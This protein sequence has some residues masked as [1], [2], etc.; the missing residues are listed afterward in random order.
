MGSRSPSEAALPTGFRFVGRDRELELLVA[1]LSRPPTVVLVE[2][3]AGIGKSRLV[4][5]AA[6]ALTDRP[7]LTGFCH[8]L[9]EPHPFGP[10]VD[11]L[12]EAGTALPGRGT[13]PPSTGALAPLLPDLADRLPPPPPRPD[14]PR[15]VRQQLIRAVRAFLAALGPAVLLVEDLHWADDATRELLLLLHRDLPRQLALA[16]TYRAD[17]LPS[18]TPPLGTALRQS[19]GVGTVRLHLEPLSETE[20]D[21]LAQ[22]VMGPAADVELVRVLYQ[23]CEGVPLVAEEDLRTLVEHSRRHPTG[24]AGVLVRAEVPASL[25]EA[26]TERLTKLSPTAAAISAAAAVIGAPASEALLTEVAGLPAEHGGEALSEAL[27]AA[28]LQETADHLYTYRHVLAQQAA[29]E[30]VPGPQRA[31]LH[32]R[33]IEVLRAR[34][35]QPLVQIAYHLK[36]LGDR[37]EWLRQ[38]RAAAEQAVSVGDHGTAAALLQQLL[39][40]PALEIEARSQIALA[41][42]RILVNGVDSRASGVALRGIL[43][44]PQLD[45]ATRG[46]IRL[47][48]GLLMINHDS[49]MAGFVEVEKAVPELHELP[50]RA[51]R[52]MIALAMNER[53]DAADRC[54]TWLERAD[55]LLR[56]GPYPAMRATAR[57]TRLTLLARAAD[58]SVWPLLDRLPRHSDDFEELRQS[59]RAL[60]NVGELALELGHDDRG[61]VLLEEGRTLAGRAGMPHIECYSRT[62]LLRLDLLRGDWAGI[63]ERFGQLAQEYPDI[64]MVAEERALARARL[65]EAHGELDRAISRLDD[66]AAISRH[67]NQVTAASRAAAGTVLLHLAQG[68]HDAAWAAAVP[69]VEAYR[70]AGAWPRA[71]GLVP[72]AVAAALVHGEQPYAERLVDDAQTALT[73]RDAPGA[74]AELHAA[75]GLLA[76]QDDPAAGAGQFGLAAAAW[77]R[78]GRPYEAARC[79]ERQGTALAAGD[80]DAAV[81]LLNE[82]AAVFERLGATADAGRCRRTLRELGQRRPAA[83]GRPSY[84]TELSPREREVAELI[85]RGATNREIAQA[86]V[87]SPRTVEQHAA[88]V[89]RKLG[90]VRKDVGE[91]LDRE[92]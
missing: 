60:Y 18:G 88:Q 10:V 91:A 92:T 58:P 12:R 72:A 71:T 8:P 56:D 50:E 57:A 32:R 40:T 76:E 75:R 34:S 87:L 54:W 25:R 63:E 45:D 36:A 90:V 37:E 27:D 81:G 85:A 41:L 2:G 7:V 26:V 55:E 68:A 70:R 73:G 4:R 29:Y 49:D 84:G 38:G 59:A 82:A 22:D 67:G 86:L 83:R 19:P 43:A 42:A 61:A 17:D 24:L 30:Y 47:T 20:V 48:L 62:A 9:R 79:S 53:G 44:D 13:L 78:I 80:P 39:A 28:L 46:E 5:E 52:A 77:Q 14:D 66:A 64:V 6:A 1:V 89:L 35:P 23:R 11:A 74:V 33:A 31:R 15:D 16:L 3:E 65:A 21:A 51:A 69:A